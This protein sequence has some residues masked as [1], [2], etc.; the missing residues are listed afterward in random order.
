MLEARVCP[1]CG[2]NEFTRDAPAVLRLTGFYYD[3]PGFE[4]SAEERL[5]IERDYD[6]LTCTDCGSEFEPDELV[7]PAQYSGECPS[8]GELSMDCGGLCDNCDHY[9]RTAA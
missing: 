7:T 6:E 5:D 8:C 4:E 9:E 1:D 3:G 2:N